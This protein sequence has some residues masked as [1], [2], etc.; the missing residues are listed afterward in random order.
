MSV[1]SSEAASVGIKRAG[2]ISIADKRRF[3]TTFTV[4]RCISIVLLNEIAC[5]ARVLNVRWVSVILKE[6]SRKYFQD[7]LYLVFESSVSHFLIATI[8]LAVAKAILE[9]VLTVAGDRINAFFSNFLSSTASL[10]FV[11][12]LT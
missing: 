9:E 2:L 7:L 10:D 3:I 11:V 5:V 1:C 4:S 8:A 12:L 6:C